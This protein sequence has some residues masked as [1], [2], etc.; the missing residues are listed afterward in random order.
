M[1]RHRED[2]VAGVARR[3]TTQNVPMQD[4]PDEDIIERE[5]STA[6]DGMGDERSAHISNDFSNSKPAPVPA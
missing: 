6:S 5:V 3:K 1:L 2:I 4:E